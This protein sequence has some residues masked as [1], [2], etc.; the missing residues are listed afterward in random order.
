MG[1]RP[2]YAS[3]LIATMYDRRIK[4]VSDIMDHMEYSIDKA[5]D[6]GTTPLFVELFKRRLT[7]YFQGQGHPSHPFIYSSGLVTEYDIE[8]EKSDPL[9]RVQHFLLACTESDLLPVQSSF[10][11]KVRNCSIGVND[12]LTFK[13]ISFHSRHSILMRTQYAHIPLFWMA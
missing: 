5:A 13:S 9:L 12:F 10:A 7:L 3:A 4:S 11:I 8:R 1:L 6:D 2:G